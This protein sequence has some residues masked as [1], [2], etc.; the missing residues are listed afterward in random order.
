ML[1]NQ[2]NREEAFVVLQEP[3]YPEGELE[4]DISAFKKKLNLSGKE[5]ENIL[6]ME[7]KTFF[8]YQNNYKI[9]SF[10]RRLV[11]F[12]RHKVIL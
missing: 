2:L 12:L 3:I 9:L 1:S 10:L 6:S 7:P 4:R 8:D 5:F 11:S